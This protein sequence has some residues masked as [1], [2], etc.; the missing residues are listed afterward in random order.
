[1]KFGPSL[2]CNFIL[3]LFFSGESRMS[4]TQPRV[5]PSRLLLMLKHPVGEE[6]DQNDA[7]L[8]KE[9]QHL[10]KEQRVHNI[11]RYDKSER[12][13]QYFMVHMND[14]ITEFNCKEF[15]QKKSISKFSWKFCH[16]TTLSRSKIVFLVQVFVFLLLI[17]RCIVKLTILKP[18]FEETLV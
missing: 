17:L 12:L 4:E 8:P 3:K 11:V 9:I 15:Q 16:Q 10:V 2:I 13:S 5:C 7:S 18:N 14:F 1:M 6:I